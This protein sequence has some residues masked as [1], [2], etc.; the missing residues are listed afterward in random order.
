MHTFTDELS[1][2]YPMP[3]SKGGGG[4]RCHFCLGEVQYRRFDLPTISI[5]LIN[6]PPISNQFTDKS[7]LSDTNTVLSTSFAK[8]GVSTPSVRL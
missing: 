6:V 2:A 3:F 7:C 5:M 8:V 1:G 4:C